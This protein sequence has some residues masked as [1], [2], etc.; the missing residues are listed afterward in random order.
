M[1]LGLETEY[2]FLVKNEAW[3][4][5]EPIAIKHISQHYI[6]RTQENRVQLT[7]DHNAGEAAVIAHFAGGEI[8][9]PIPRDT[10]ASFG[11]DNLRALT[12]DR[13]QIVIDDKTEARIRSSDDQYVFTVKAKTGE[14]ASRRELEFAIAPKSALALIAQCEHSLEKIRHVLTIDGNKWE[15][16]VFQGKNASL[17]TVEV[18]ADTIPAQLPDWVGQNVTGNDK[19]SNQQLARIPYSQWAKS[20]AV[21]AV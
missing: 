15:V 12:N 4:A 13:G 8:R 11:Q 19:Y 1:S 14:V 3:K 9:F 18:E 16:D 2:K 17:T 6:P 7:L 5:V 21:V 10:L 20:A